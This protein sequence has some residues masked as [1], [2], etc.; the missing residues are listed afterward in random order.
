MNNN[1]HKEAG[2]ESVGQSGY[3]SAT[4]VSTAANF[5]MN[6]KEPITHTF[7]TYIK[8]RA[9]GKLD[10]KLWHS[11]AVDSTWDMGQ[12]AVGGEPGGIWEIVE[13]YI[14]DG[15]TE[16]DG[17]IIEDTQA[18]VTFGGHVSRTVA[19]GKSFWSDEVHLELPDGHYLAFTWTLR[20][21]APGK[22]FPYNVEGMLV[23]AYDA[24]GS[25]AAQESAEFFKP[26][27]NLLVL[28]SFI[29]Y[30]KNVQKKLVFLGD[31]ITQGVRTFKDAYEYWSALIADGLGSDYGV[32]NIGS[33]WGRAYDVA[34]GGPWLHKAKQGDE[35]M[36][37]LGVNDLDIGQRSAEELL[38]D[39]MVI[40]SELRSANPEV[41]ILLTT[42]PPFNF[43]GDKE[44]AWREV[45]TSIL[46]S[47]P[48]GVNRVFDI[49]RV[50]SMP[51]PYEHRIRSEYMSGTDDPHPNGAAGQRIA[52]EFLEWY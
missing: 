32:W 11:N 24:P 38:R 49:A 13:A 5:I 45:N 39:L 44:Q 20:T 51:A 26:S 17:S 9:H 47:P 7:R 43:E 21:L 37:V 15:G 50:L 14:A 16:L 1:Q 52:K 3:T 34:A 18:A 36:I 40:I 12:E 10:L 33:G 30:K 28:P 4:V 31:S 41:S 8:V 22:S 35:V 42:V 48:V 29:G 23:T 25:L 2:L 6:K 19:A 46:T 27:E